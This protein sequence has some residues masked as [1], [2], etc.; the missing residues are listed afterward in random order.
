[1]DIR[2][3]HGSNNQITISTSSGAQ[4][5]GTKAS[6]LSFNQTGTLHPDQ[7]WNSDPTKS[8]L[9]TV[10]LTDPSGGTTDLIATGA[11]QSG[12]IAGYLNMRD[13]VL[14]QAQSQIDQIAAQMSSALSDTTTAGTA[15]APGPQTGFS[16][17]IGNVSNGNNI[18]VTYKDA[19]GVERNR[20]DHPGR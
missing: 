6:L 18:Q 1:M 9:G 20:H 14:V 16:V 2:V 4:L 8:G 15:V 13:N 10:T 11:I 3:T 17:D 19:G 5:V 7:Q 12:E